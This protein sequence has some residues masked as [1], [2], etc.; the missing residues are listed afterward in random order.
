[1]IRSVA[2]RGDSARVV[3]FWRPPGVKTSV[4]SCGAPLKA[5]SGAR[6]EANG[7]LS[8]EAKGGTRGTERSL[9]HAASKRPITTAHSC[10]WQVSQFSSAAKASLPLWHLPQDFP[11]Y[12]VSI[13]YDDSFL[14]PYDVSGKSAA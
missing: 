2:R 5:K 1:M 6:Y 12:I 7:R 14:E 4:A 13:R 9:C 3:A 10:R 8:L 11:W